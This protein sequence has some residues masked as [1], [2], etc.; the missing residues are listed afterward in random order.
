MLEQNGRPSGALRAF[1]RAATAAAVL[2]PGLA[3]SPSPALAQTMFEQMGRTIS[4]LREQEFVT[5]ALLAGVLIFAA[6]TAVMLMRTHRAHRAKLATAEAEI[7]LLRGEAERALALLLAE[8]QIIVVWSNSSSDPTIIGDTSPLTGTQPTRRLLAFGSWLDAGQAHAMDQAVDMLRRRGEKFSLVLSTTR[9]HHVEAE[10]RP[11]GGAA[12]LRLREVTGAK[13]DHARLAERHAKLAG[14][15][16]ELRQ[17]LDL[18]PAPIWVRGADGRLVFANRAYANAVEAND[19]A[20]AVARGIELLDSTARAEA[21]RTRA[22]GQPFAKRVPAVVAGQRRVLDVFELGVKKGAAGIGIDASEAERL[23]SELARTIDAHRRTLDQLATAVAIFG[24]DERLVFY[25]DAYRKLFDFEAA[26]LDERPR[27]SVILDRLREKR[28]L[29]EQADF[30]AWKAQLHEAYRA[31]EPREHWWHLPGGRTLRVVTTANPEGGV[32]YICD[33]ITERLELASRFNALNRTQGETLDALAEAVAVFGSDGRLKL[34]NRSFAELWELS[35]ETLA[36]LPHIEKIGSLCRTF[37]R[38]GAAAWRALQLA[39]T[40]IGERN[41]L[42]R[43]IECADGRVL[44]CAA[45]PLPDGGTLVTF[46]DVSDSVRVERALIERNEA[47]EQADSLKSAFVGHVSYEL[48]SPLTTIIGFAQLL[49]DPLIGPLND[50][51]R[52]YV[53]HI[54]DSSATLLAIINDILDLATIDAGTMQLDLDEVDVKSA[55]EAAAEG[56]RA[57]MNERG[58][59]LAIDVPKNIGSFVADEKRVRQVLFN[60]LSNA[61]GFSPAGETITLSAERGRDGIIF[62]VADRGPGIPPELHERIFGRFE[63]HTLGS[64][65]RGAGLGLSI[66]RSLMELHGGSI[67]LDSEPGAGT[68]ATCVFPI[69]AAAGSQAAE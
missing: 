21:E 7:A 16:E 54:T 18:A 50:K 8:P 52:E 38:D 31:P 47:L 19:P 13:L 5:L 51:Q 15:F 64:Q 33:D 37:L 60:L 1:L 17:L 29:P 30:R 36:E 42:L 26:F 67:N 41:P 25:N 57:R 6:A 46:R 58:L 68:V 59:R 32:T 22:E 53:R 27:D 61:A 56:V 48:R 62:R 28:Q 49:D 43:Q 35:P 44:D 11:I 10:G 63:S 12:V 40:G 23:R 39:V 69:H 45:V 65:H 14:E 55:V 4:G 66:V 2:I 9:G 34:F 20:D 3:V 24:Q